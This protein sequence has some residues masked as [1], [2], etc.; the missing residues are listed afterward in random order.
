MSDQNTRIRLRNPS[1]RKEDNPKF[2]VIV[3][4]HNFIMEQW[5][6]INND[7]FDLKQPKLLFRGYKAR[8]KSFYKPM[9]KLQS[10]F[11]VWNK[12]AHELLLKTDFSFSED[13]ESVI[14]FIHYTNILRDMIGQL[15]HHMV[16]IAD[17]FVKVQQRH[18]NQ[19]NFVVAITSFA[20]TFIALIVTLFTIF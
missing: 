20:L 12:K 10:K 4:E 5:N 7:L 9:E 17:N 15:D 6:K 11:I 14:G 2:Y 3:D 1:L 19:F 18:S 13:E 16:L 8:L